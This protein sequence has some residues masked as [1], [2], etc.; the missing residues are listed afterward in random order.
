MISADEVQV[1]F[2]P[3]IVR[4]DTVTPRSSSFVETLAGRPARVMPVPSLLRLAGDAVA[5]LL[6]AGDPRVVAAVG[7]LHRDVA[8]SVALAYFALKL[9]RDDD[10]A[11][12][13]AS[14]R[15]ALDLPLPTS[16]CHLP[17]LRALAESDALSPTTLALARSTRTLSRSGLSFLH[18]AGHSLRR[19]AVVDCEWLANLDFVRRLPALAALDLSGCVALPSEALAALAVEDDDKES[20]S[21][22]AR[23]SVTR[24][25]G[26]RKS[27]RVARRRGGA[28]REGE[29]KNKTGGAAPP[30]L[31]S[32][33][34]AGCASLTD[35]IGAH[36]ARLPASLR[37][38]DLT[39]CRRVGNLFVD[40][41]TYEHRLAEWRGSAREASSAARGRV[42]FGGARFLRGAS[43]RRTRRNTRAG[44]ARITAGSTTRSR[45][46][47]ARDA[48]ARGHARR[49]RRRGAA[50]VAAEA[51]DVRRAR[52]CAGVGRAG[53]DAL[54]AAGIITS[55]PSRSAAREESESGSSLVGGGGAP[56]PD[57]PL[58]DDD[59]SSPGCARSRS[60]A[61]ATEGWTAFLRA[62]REE[63][64][65]GF[66]AFEAR[67][68]ARIAAERAAEA[69]VFAEAERMWRASPAGAI[70]GPFPIQRED[71]KDPRVGARDV[72]PS[73][74]RDFSSAA[75]SMDFFVGDTL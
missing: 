61:L 2:I 18:L 25:S 12:S 72:R 74:D 53:I 69:E 16:S 60:A 17:A 19:L 15:P 5:E 56:S 8:E 46:G 6:L 67:E 35:A 34:L 47:R 62:V 4:D 68:A 20:P 30:R 29:L 31:A 37:R 48:S 3:I 32:L 41:A 13:P 57:D 21:S 75:I 44:R 55:S 50:R 52:A 36:L 24:A 73:G 7:D 27:A 71:L 45:L 70:G 39:G 63:E 26:R 65:A 11:P 22:S 58:E 28:E 9:K 10:A 49:R 23:A 33:T 1:N 51:S 54:E 38:L 14:S 66:A 40:T 43:E 59:A 42:Y 64:E